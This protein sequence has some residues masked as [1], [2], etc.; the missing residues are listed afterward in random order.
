MLVTIDLSRH[1]APEIFSSF[2]IFN[3]ISGKKIAVKARK[4]KDGHS[5][6][7]YREMPLPGGAY[8]QVILHRQRGYAKQ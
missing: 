4:E 3:T 2:R 7:V 8:K 1:T 6:N 5:P